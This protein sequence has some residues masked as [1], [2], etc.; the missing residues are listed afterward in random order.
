[1]KNIILI[2]CIFTAFIYAEI[3][4]ID[5]ENY[6]AKP[7]DAKLGECIAL[8]SEGKLP[9]NFKCLGSK[10][11]V[12]ERTKR[13][14]HPVKLRIG[15]TVHVYN[16]VT[17]WDSYTLKTEST[18]FGITYHIEMWNETLELRVKNITATHY[19]FLPI[20]SKRTSNLYHPSARIDENDVVRLVHDEHYNWL[21]EYYD[22]TD[23]SLL[24]KGDYEYNR[25]TEDIMFNGYCYK[26]DVKTRKSIM[27]SACK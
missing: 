6:A 24:W 11:F 15:D 17:V 25:E 2:V 20:K 8:Y 5:F 4:V 3:G 16:T 18:K 9:A 21:L 13:P 26:N 7:Y 27:P 14:S 10:S 1:M 23:G 22:N 12:D 19:E